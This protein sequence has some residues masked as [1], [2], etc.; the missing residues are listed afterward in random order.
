MKYHIRHAPPNP[1]IEHANRVLEEM[2]A[3]CTEIVSRGGGSTIDLAKYVA[4]KLGVRHSTIPTTAGTGSEVTKYCVLTIDGKK[5]TLTDE[6]YIPDSYTL[7][8]T[9]AVSLPKEITISSGLDALSQALEALWSKNS[10]PD[11]ELY[12]K[13][14]IHL[15]FKSL[16]ECVKNPK[17]ERAR[18]DMLIAAN[19]SGRAINIT[20][21][22]VCHALSYPLT[23]WYNISHGTACALSLA[24]FTKKALGIN[25]ADFI[26][27][28]NLPQYDIDKER[29]AN[30]VLKSEK[31]K[32]YPFEITHEDLLACY[33]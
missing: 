19:F 31:L 21:T 13:V 11:S 10:T 27:Q 9:F 15:V 7:D 8:P 20:K 14:A 6:K 1:T 23:M 22:N 32:D 28:F 24:Y 2:P 30:E 12:S 29:V 25:I 4:R 18:M 17:N 33:L 3:D 16:P 26:K 5:E